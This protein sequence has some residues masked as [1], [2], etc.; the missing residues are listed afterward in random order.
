M[1]YVPVTGVLEAGDYLTG[2]LE[3]ADYRTAGPV[4]TLANHRDPRWMRH[5]CAMPVLSSG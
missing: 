3:Q 1:R 5:T 2:N 4:R